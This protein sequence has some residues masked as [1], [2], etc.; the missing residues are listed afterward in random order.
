MLNV[1]NDALEELLTIQTPS[2]TNKDRIEL[3]KNIIGKSFYTRQDYLRHNKE[4][5]FATASRDL[6]NAVENGILE[7]TGEKRLTKYRFKL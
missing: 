5:S 7:K 4:I 2:I 3:F 1:I 6:R